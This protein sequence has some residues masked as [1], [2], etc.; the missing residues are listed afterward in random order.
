MVADSTLYEANAKAD[1]TTRTGSRRECSCH[2]G[3]SE[4]VAIGRVTTTIGRK[5][6][7]GGHT[8]GKGKACQSLLHRQ[9]SRNVTQIIS[10][11]PL[12]PVKSITPLSASLLLGAG[13]LL[14]APVTQAQTTFRGEVRLR[15]S[16]Q[17]EAK[18]GSLTFVMNGRMTSPKSD[19]VAT[20]TGGGLFRSTTDAIDNTSF[21][22]PLKVNVNVAGDISR[23]NDSVTVRV[24]RR[25]I[26]FPGGKVR[27][28]R[29]VN[30]GLVMKQRI[31]GKGSYR[32]TFK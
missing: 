31:K 24:S 25:T 19:E 1:S 5:H 21:T 30:P 3:S 17:N 18:P 27:L 14:V 15:G 6:S 16:I 2:L 9:E 29:P 23:S 22:G 10:T 12:Y 4:N 20:F 32:Y 7:P 8:A 11:H 13:L 26:I 28:D